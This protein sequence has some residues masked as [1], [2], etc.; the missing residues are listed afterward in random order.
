MCCFQGDAL[1]SRLNAVIRLLLA[2]SES[3]TIA[4]YHTPAFIVSEGPEKC[5]SHGQRKLRKL[6]VDLDQVK[7][8]FLVDSSKF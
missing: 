6:D 3:T 4:M 8:Y 1:I 2:K 7:F 5:F